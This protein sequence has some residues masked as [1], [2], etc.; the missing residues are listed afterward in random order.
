MWRKAPGHRASSSDSPCSATQ[1]HR[2]TRSS[3]DR[4]FL[5]SPRGARVH[6]APDNPRPFH[7]PLSSTC[8][9]RATG[10]FCRR[11][12]H[13]RFSKRHRPPLTSVSF[14]P[15]LAARPSII[16]R[17]S[18]PLSSRSE[19][20]IPTSEIRFAESRRHLASPDQDTLSAGCGFSGI[21]MRRCAFRVRL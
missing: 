7:Q 2:Q 14:S 9:A 6:C 12:L 3:G 10:R 4:P 13:R 19:L 21:G 18:R 17:A 5:N 20:R 8:N 15:S 16:L 1:G 11:R